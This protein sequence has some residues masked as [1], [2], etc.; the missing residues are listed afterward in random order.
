MRTFFLG[1]I[2]AVAAGLLLYFAQGYFDG[3][4][5]DQSIHYF[6]YKPS[7]YFDQAKAIEWEGRLG[8]VTGSGTSKEGRIAVTA[9]VIENRGSNPIENQR[10]S[11]KDTYEDGLSKG[12]I[13]F[14]NDFTPEGGKLNTSMEIKDGILTID[15]KLLNSGE[16]HR[17]WVISDRYSK[18][19]TVIRKPG[20]EIRGWNAKIYTKE[21]PSFWTMDLL[22]FSAFIALI[23]AVIAA[24]F[25]YRYM[26]SMI[27]LNGLDIAELVKSAQK[28]KAS[29]KAK[30]QQANVESAGP[31]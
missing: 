4:K 7:F 17:F 10:V 16:I 25:D 20:M 18:L 1:I 31:N 8:N 24:I 5:K 6:E 14:Q 12:I 23:S 29:R 28:M 30:G 26:K 2:T 27:E 22:F 19:S 9:F 13:D 21:E 15:Y 3:Q 11:I